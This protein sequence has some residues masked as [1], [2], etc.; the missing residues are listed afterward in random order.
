MYNHD[1]GGSAIVYIDK[2]TIMITERLWWLC[3]RIYRQMYNHD[4]G[5]SAIGYIDKCTI[6]IV[7][8]VL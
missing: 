8:V 5:G 1:C 2:R 6:M 4:C 7:V 3:Y